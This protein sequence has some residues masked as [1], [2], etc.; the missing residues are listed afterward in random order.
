MPSRQHLAV[1]IS[2][3]YIFLLTTIKLRAFFM[4][5][6]VIKVL[7]FA[8]PSSSLFTYKSESHLLVSAPFHL[9]AWIGEGSLKFHCNSA[10]VGTCR[11]LGVS[12]NPPLTLIP[13]AP[14][15]ASA[16]APA[17]ISA[18]A[19]T[20]TGAST[21]LASNTFAPSPSITQTGTP[22]AKPHVLSST[23][24]SACGSSGL[25]ISNLGMKYVFL[26]IY[27]QPTHHT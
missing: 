9:F 5:L 10:Y 22:H 11:D 21:Q 6:S 14:S 24:A 2:F 16:A 17:T 1:L 15:R 3:H 18:K 8:F 20:S 12:F 4:L 7:D 26:C 25:S 13:S 27:W 23:D 19:P